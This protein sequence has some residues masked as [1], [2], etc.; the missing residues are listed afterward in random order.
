[1]S[2]MASIIEAPDG[3]MPPESFDRSAK[4]KLAIDAMLEASKAISIRLN[5]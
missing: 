3:T 1:M 4:P 5:S 2:V